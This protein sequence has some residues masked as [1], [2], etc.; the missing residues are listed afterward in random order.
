[1]TR[2]GRHQKGQ[3]PTKKTKGQPADPHQ[4]K[5]TTE[6]ASLTEQTGTD[7][8]M[9][10]GLAKKTGLLVAIIMVVTAIW[11]SG[12]EPFYARF[13]TGT[14]NVVLGLG[15]RETRVEVEKQEE[16][17]FFVVQTIIEGR[18]ASY[19]QVLG[20]LLLPV[21]MI[22]SWQIYMA[23]FL[24]RKR[25][26]RYTLINFGLFLS[27]QVLFL[28][29]LTAYYTSDAARYIYD[30]MMDSFYIFALIIILADNIRHPVFLSLLKIR[31]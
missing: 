26:I 30:M 15:G 6:P 22:L 5:N 2:P 13:L 27:L 17:T 4:K 3:H 29:L 14:T 16:K 24:K 10:Y 23:F 7:P 20:P 12:F 8:W 1:M 28:L 19:P 9:K 18:R 11:F 25:W 31:N 21:V